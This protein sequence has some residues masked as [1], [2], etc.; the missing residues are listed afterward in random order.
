MLGALLGIAFALQGVTAEEVR[1]VYVDAGLVVS[2]PTYSTDGVATLIVNGDADQ[3][4]L[5]VFV[6]PDADAAAAEHRLAHAREEARWNSTLA[7]SDDGGPQ[8]LTGYGMSMWRGNVALVQ[9]APFEDVGAH[10]HEIECGEDGTA[11]TP[12]PTTRVARGY[13]AA[14]DSLLMRGVRVSQ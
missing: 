12:L 7:H 2:T 9:A 10:A 4:T 11:I 1:S 3:P 5:R 6:F 14:L 8:L 13:Q